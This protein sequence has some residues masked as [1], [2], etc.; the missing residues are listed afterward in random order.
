MENTEV[1]NPVAEATQEVTPEAEAPETEQSEDAV[2]ET[3]EPS[4]TEDQAEQ[5][6]EIGEWTDPETGKVHKVSKDLLPKIMMEADYT[7]K[8]QEIAERRREIEAQR[9]AYEQEV[10]FREATW[11]ETAALVNIEQRLAQF[12][13]MDWRRYVA[14]RPQEAQAAQAEFLQLQGEYSRLQNTVQAKRA[15]IASQFEQET[16]TKLTKAVEELRKPNPAIGWD[17]KFDQQRSAELTKFISERF[18]IPPAEQAKAARSPGW[19][20]LA[21]AA[22]IGIET[23]AKSKQATKPVPPQ[24]KPVPTV[25]A[26]K[27]NTAI[28]NPDKLSPEEWVKWREKQIAKRQANR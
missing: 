17:G 7:R 12:Q 22:K 2:Q 26:G 18:G 1:T 28:V 6:E 9:E 13:N 27:T 5:V 15:H 16:A 20:Q 14:E 24:S 11:Q 3:T 10:Q 21:H 19:V 23:L 4:E 25:A 8:T